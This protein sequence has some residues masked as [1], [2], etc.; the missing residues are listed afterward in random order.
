[1]RVPLTEVSAIPNEGAITVDFFGRETLVLKVDGRAR[2]VMNT[3]THLGGP[4]EC[5]GDRFVCAWHQAE[6]DLK[7]RQIKGPAKRES[8][9]MFLPTRVEDGTLYYVYGSDEADPS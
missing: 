9:L 5:Q 6:F 3:C 4:L 1:M 8:A 7:G 2:A